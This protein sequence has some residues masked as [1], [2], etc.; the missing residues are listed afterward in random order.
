MQANH[1]LVPDMM[2]PGH[3]M[4]P[5]QGE[6]ADLRAELGVSERLR[7]AMCS[8]ISHTG[9][10]VLSDCLAMMTRCKIPFSASGRLCHGF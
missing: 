8:S 6:V 7:I 10:E 3:E 9:D 4:A 5:L 1:L 2:T